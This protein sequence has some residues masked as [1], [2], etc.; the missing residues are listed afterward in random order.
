MLNLFDI[1]ALIITVT[2]VLSYLN[3]RVLRLP[4]TIGVM[5]GGL[6]LSLVLLG[7]GALHVIRPAR[8]EA[9]VSSFRFDTLLMNGMLSFL[10]FAGS[11]N[12][13]LEQLRRHQGTVAILATAGTLIS[14]A[15]IGLAT[16]QV[17]GLL[18]MQVSF[19]AALVFGALISPTDPV[20][21]LSIL[22]E[23]NAPA[24]LKMLVVGESLFNDGIGVVLYTIALGVLATS[25]APSASHVGLLF[26]EAA[27]G[28]VLWGL[29]L[30]FVTVQMLRRVDDYTVEILLTLAV[31]TGGYAM[32]ERLHVSGPLTMVVAGIIVGNP[33]RRLGMSQ[34][35][36]AHLDT[37]W[38]VIDEILNAVLFVLIGFETLVLTI[39]PGYFMAAAIAIVVSLAAR[40]ISVVLPAAAMRPWTRMDRA[41]VRIMTWGGL[42]GGIAVALALGLPARDERDLL[43]FM[44]YAVVVFSILVQ[45]LT[46]RPLLLR[47]Y[48]SHRGESEG[49][50]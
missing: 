6:V 46:V 15:I 5:V 25:G 35:T 42:R 31:V 14:T 24:D 9:L 47:L 26:L 17:F 19:A 44:T 27:G 36:Q 33:G 20:A 28:G 43:I 45:G 34:R 50:E 48:P 32:A 49:A 40:W 22:G 39:E 37:F 11:L 21:V 8:V 38:L 30:G 41:T 1:V 10:L 18:G 7:L 2:A 13:D 23:T 4:T 3:R 12:V 29:V 16:W